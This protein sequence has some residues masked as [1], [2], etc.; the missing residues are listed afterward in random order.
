[1]LVPNTLI[2]IYQSLLYLGIENVEHLI[3]FNKHWIQGLVS[4]VRH[5]M[6]DLL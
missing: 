2:D 5:F 6:L 4:G 3:D 1:M